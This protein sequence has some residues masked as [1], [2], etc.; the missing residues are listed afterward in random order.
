M[1]AKR[2]ADRGITLADPPVVQELTGNT[3]WA[4]LWLLPRLY[5]GYT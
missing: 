3:R 5:V 1:D 4:W 2:T